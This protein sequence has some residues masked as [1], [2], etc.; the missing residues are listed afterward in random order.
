MSKVPDL[1]PKV[2]FANAEGQP[3]PFI[4]QGFE[5][6][7]LIQSLSAGKGAKGTAGC[8]ISI[9]EMIERMQSHLNKPGIHGIDLAC[10]QAGHASI[11]SL[12]KVEI[13]WKAWYSGSRSVLIRLTT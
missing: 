8:E 7:G 1:L 3:D 12:V 10:C 4:L 2:P 13:S 9:A 5:K 11:L 6:T